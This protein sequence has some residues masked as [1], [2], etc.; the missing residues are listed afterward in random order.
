MI[1][2]VIGW[3]RSNA[4]YVEEH[5]VPDVQAVMKRHHI[6]IVTC[7]YAFNSCYYYGKYLQLCD[8]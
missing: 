7:M 3:K 5:F 8:R 2:V 1:L 4:I 6:V